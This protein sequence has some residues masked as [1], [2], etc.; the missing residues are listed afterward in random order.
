MQLEKQTEGWKTDHKKYIDVSF[1]NFDGTRNHMVKAYGIVDGSVEDVFTF[2]MDNYGK[3]KE[4]HPDCLEFRV[5]EVYSSNLD[6][7]YEADSVK[8]FS[9][10]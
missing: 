8:F 5:L 6:L 7:I 10:R 9:A 1:K 2:V 3:N 4:I